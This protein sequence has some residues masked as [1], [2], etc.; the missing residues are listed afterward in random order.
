MLCVR[1]YCQVDEHWAPNDHR[2]FGVLLESASVLSD[3]AKSAAGEQGIVRLDDRPAD[4]AEQLSESL[5]TSKLETW[6]ESLRKVALRRKPEIDATFA[7]VRGP[8]SPAMQAWLAEHGGDYDAVL[9][10]GIPFDVVPRS[11]ETLAQL[12]K[13]PKI[14]T[15][16]HFH[17]DDRFYYWARYFNAFSSADKTLLFSPFLAERLGG[18]EKFAV[19]PGGGE[20][21]ALAVDPEDALLDYLELFYNLRRAG[22]ALRRVERMKSAGGSVSASTASLMA[23]G[24][25]NRWPWPMATSSSR[26]S[27]IWRSLSHF[28]AINSMP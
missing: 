1:L 23:R 14:V 28:S 4:L 17:G 15:L 13:R 27:T 20:V 12:A 11:V 9:V 19:V 6:V 5:R 3:S 2:P 18:K 24:S 7:A 8:H 16:P 26:M 22:S 21:F 10:Q 25:P